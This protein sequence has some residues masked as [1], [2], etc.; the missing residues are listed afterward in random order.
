MEAQHPKPIERFAGLVIRRL[1]AAILAWSVLRVF[2]LTAPA[3][4]QAGRDASRARFQGT[5]PRRR[6]V[7]AG[8]LSIGVISEFSH[9][10][11]T[12]PAASLCTV[13][14]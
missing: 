11:F 9:S 1:A 4:G 6:A 10:W 12:T 8:D 13:G 2:G 7:R 5:R 3:H 14:P